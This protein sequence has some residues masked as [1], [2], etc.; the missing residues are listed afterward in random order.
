VVWRPGKG[1]IGLCVVEGRDIGFDVSELDARLAG[2]TRAEWST[3]PE[4]ARLGLSFDEWELLRD[5]YGVIVATP[6]VRER[7]GRST[8]IGLRQPRRPVRPARR[9][10][11]R[12]GARRA[13]ERGNRAGTGGSVTLRGYAGQPRRTVDWPAGEAN[14]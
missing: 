5:K 3:L 6:I 8:A 9:A 1:V 4:D 13:A 11:L 10:V 14:R 7:A 12:R 2:V